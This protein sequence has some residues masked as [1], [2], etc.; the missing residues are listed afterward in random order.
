MSDI[1]SAISIVYGLLFA[2]FLQWFPDV[3]KASGIKYNPDKARDIDFV[4]DIQKY[5]VMPLLIASVLLTLIILPLFFNVLWES[6]MTIKK[7]SFNAFAYYDV[8]LSVIL[9]I[10]CLSITL[11]GYLVITFVKIKKELRRK[12]RSLR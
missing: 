12:Q 3:S 8:V 4:Q 6:L 11:S 9:Y 10:S 1:L 2:I 5:K 7:Y